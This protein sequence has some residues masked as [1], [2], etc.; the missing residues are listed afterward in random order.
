MRLHGERR[1]HQRRLSRGPASRI[2]HRALGAVVV[3]P[4]LPRPCPGARAQEIRARFADCLP[5]LGGARKGPRGAKR[6]RI[7]PVPPWPA[8]LLEFN[9]IF[10]HRDLYMTVKLGE[11]RII[12]SRLDRR[13]VGAPPRSWRR[14]FASRPK[15][16]L[17]KFDAALAGR[18]AQSDFESWGKLNLPA[19]S[20]A[21]RR[22]SRSRSFSIVPAS[23]LRQARR[24]C[25]QC[26][27]QAVGPLMH[28]KSYAIDGETLR[29][30]AASADK[31]TT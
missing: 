18:S 7:V 12:E 2:H 4:L 17:C 16:G 5:G 25:R 11:T 20:D 29:T 8:R 21:E 19:R 26:S 30:P 6:E 3:L 15:S 31:T 28:L 1:Q 22:G 13:A 24:P 9:I 14:K 23:R 27:V 10:Y